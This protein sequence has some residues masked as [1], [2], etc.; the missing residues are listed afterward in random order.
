[1]SAERSDG[2]G[3]H[4][5]G[6]FADADF[7]RDIA[8]DALIFGASHEAQGFADAGFG[9]NVEIGRLLELSGERLL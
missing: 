7:V 8:G 4:G 3:Q 2:A 6:A 9:K 5:G 1:M